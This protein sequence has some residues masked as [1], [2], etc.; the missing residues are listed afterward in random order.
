[1]V[2]APRSP[3]SNKGYKELDKIEASVPCALLH[4]SYIAEQEGKFQK[5]QPQTNHRTKQGEAK[6]WMNQK[7]RDV[8][9]VNRQKRLWKV[10]EQEALFPKW[11]AGCCGLERG[12][13][14]GEVGKGR[15]V[16]RGQ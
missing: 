5:K 7:V 16:Q 12:R 9:S 1:M 2:P 4:G 3:Q 8:G 15:G 10:S 6:W 11:W 13:K 14:R